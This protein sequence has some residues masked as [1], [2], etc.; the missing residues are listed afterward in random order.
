VWCTRWSASRVGVVVVASR[1][2]VVGVV[3][4]D[5]GS[6]FSGSKKGVCGGL[7]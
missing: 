5:L 7:D 4:V 1:V 3:L 6:I 2:G